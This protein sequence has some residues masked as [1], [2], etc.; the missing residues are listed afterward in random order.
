MF[1]IGFSIAK[2]VLP[3]PRISRK[4]FTLLGIIPP[5]SVLGNITEVIDGKL[6][7]QPKQLCYGFRD[8]N[9]K[10]AKAKLPRLADRL[11]AMLAAVALLATYLDPAQPS[12][13]AKAAC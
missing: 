5:Q 8:R 3:S 9:P 13:F 2:S 6:T 4:K 12:R 1:Q 11:R 10:V 7:F